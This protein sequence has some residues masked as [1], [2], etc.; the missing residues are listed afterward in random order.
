MN[1]LSTKKELIQEAILFVRKG[2]T[3]YINIPST[4]KE[5]DIFIL[6]FGNMSI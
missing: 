4:T 1:R 3:I 2:L 5:E 6:K